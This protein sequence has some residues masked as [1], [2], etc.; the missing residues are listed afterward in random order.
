MPCALAGASSSVLIS[1]TVLCA[2]RASLS[3]LV[4]HVSVR[5][6]VAANVRTVGLVYVR[7][8]LLVFLGFVAR[9]LLTSLIRLLFRHCTEQRFGSF[10]APIEG[11]LRR[12]CV[13]GARSTGTN[14]GIDSAPHNFWKLLLFARRYISWSANV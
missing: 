4:P 8:G 5:R 2:L 14:R 1:S 6:T 3:A 12:V 13:L 10:D 7:Q 11:L 9:S